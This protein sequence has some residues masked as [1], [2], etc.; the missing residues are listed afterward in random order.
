MHGSHWVAPPK[1]RH[2]RRQPRTPGLTG[3]SPLN[4]TDAVNA[5]APHAD[6]DPPDFGPPR[7][8]RGELATGAP[9]RWPHM[10]TRIKHCGITTL[11]DAHLA[12]EAGAWA[13][14][15]IF[16]A[17]SPRPLRLAEAQVIGAAPAAAR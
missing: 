17:G 13:L 10:A 6:T 14:G 15:M 9:L 12:A 2:A 3:S 1:K 11:E 7:S 5:W 8:E 16:W 4:L